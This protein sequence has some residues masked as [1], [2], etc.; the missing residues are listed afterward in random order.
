MGLRGE[1]DNTKA[2]QT[3]AKSAI[4]CAAIAGVAT[5][6][7]A[8]YANE[9]RQHEAKAQAASVS[10]HQAAVRIGI[11][12]VSA[13]HVNPEGD[14]ASWAGVGF[15]VEIV[16]SGVYKVRFDVPCAKTPI[17]VVTAEGTGAG[18]RACINHV[19]PDSFVV[20]TSR[21]EAPTRSKEAF[22]FVVVEPQQ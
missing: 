15:K 11:G 13:G 12:L 4:V 10:A 5:V 17:V 3:T 6:A 21:N 14:T 9:G 1:T 7:S 8:I 16:G 2:A 22:T 19:Q 18:A 20:E